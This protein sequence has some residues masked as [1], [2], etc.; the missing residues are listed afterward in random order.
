MDKMVRLYT[1]LDDGGKIIEQVRADNHD[2]ALK[3]LS[4]NSEIKFMTD[5]YSEMVTA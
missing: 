4:Y 3:K 1:F 5:F 2:E